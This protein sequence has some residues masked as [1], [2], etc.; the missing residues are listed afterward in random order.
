MSKA[1][2]MGTDS[3]RGSFWVF[4]GKIISAIVLTLG[5]IILG[6]FIGEDEYGLYTIA[7]IPSLTLLLFQDWGVSS[8]ITKFCAQFR[9]T[10]KEENLSRLI[11][12]GL[13]FSIIS[14]LL[15]TFVSLILADFLAVV[16]FEKTNATIYIVIASSTIL[17]TALMISTQSVF[18]GFEKMKYFSF[19]IICQALVQSII[20]P[21]LVYYGYGTLGAVIGYTSALVIASFLSL[22]LMY[23][24]I[25]RILPRPKIKPR[26][27]KTLR[28]L[29]NYGIPLGISTILAG[30]TVQFYSFMMAA[31]VAE[32]LIGNYRMAKNFAIF[33]TFFAVPI[34]TVL[35]PAFSKINPKS[36]TSLLK[37]VFSTSVKITALFILPATL[38]L[39]VLSDPLVATL[40]GNRWSFASFFLSLSVLHNLFSFF[41]T[42]SI[43][44]LL[45]ALGETK[46]LMKMNLIGIAIGVPLSFFFIPKY[47]IPGVILVSLSALTPTALF[48]VYWI[49]KKYGVKADFRNSGKLLLA[50]IVSALVTYVF[51]T[52]IAG[53]PW[54]QLFLGALVFVL[55]YVFCVPFFGAINYSDVCTLR[56][57][58][59]RLGIIA[60]ILEIPLQL[61]TKISKLREK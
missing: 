21:L 34:S 26:M 30:I 53:A 54:L 32:S 36:E 17:S 19:V 44:S 16:V 22:L 46:R 51:T 6:L 28:M 48:N 60:K 56:I 11:K 29:L 50:S 33:V 45:I 8:A 31:N 1:L 61:M 25:Y 42:L 2:K 47:G 49:W 12:V 18:V 52:L 14:G 24:G 41:G 15:L 3:A 7:L 59:S 10:N 9:G 35:F 37:S 27:T 43:N 20:S 39:I 4:I 58:F 23:F 55:T 38:G 5:T 57:M 13:I 40:Y